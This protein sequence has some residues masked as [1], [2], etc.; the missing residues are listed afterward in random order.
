MER[1]EELYEKIIGFDTAPI[2]YFIEEGEYLK[3]IRPIFDMLDR[4]EVI[5]VTSTITLLEVLVLPYRLGYYK[6]VEKYCEI[7]L[8][9]KNMSIYPVINDIAIESAKLRAKYGMRTP[10]AIQVATAVYAGASYFLTND[11][12]LKKIKEIKVITLDDLMTS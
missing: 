12:R 11:R 4:G 10:D 3:F 2:I 6:L 8:N 5:G 1:L 9:A 7:L